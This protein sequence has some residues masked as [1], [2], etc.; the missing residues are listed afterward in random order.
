MEDNH[1]N[2]PLFDK[3]FDH[4]RDGKIDMFEAASRYQYYV[5]YSEQWDKEHGIKHK[6]VPKKQ[7]SGKMSASDWVLLLLVTV[8]A[9]GGIIL[10][11]CFS[12][13]FW[14]SLFSFGAVAL[15]MAIMIAASSRK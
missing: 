5:K 11:I 13:K 10:T 1:S 14:C 3:M 7:G 12:D 6:P 8:I 2:M 9:W 15:D 4:N